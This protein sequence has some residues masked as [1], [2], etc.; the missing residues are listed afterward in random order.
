VVKHGRLGPGA[1]WIAVT[2]L[3]TFT[4]GI[5]ASLYWR[6]PLEDDLLKDQF[7]QENQ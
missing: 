7:K 6:V 2:G 3:T 1:G 5:A 4:L